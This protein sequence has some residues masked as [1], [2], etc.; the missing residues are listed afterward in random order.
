MRYTRIIVHMDQWSNHVNLKE[1]NEFFC[2]SYKLKM[3]NVVIFF[4]DFFKTH[5][6]VQFTIFPEF[7]LEFGLYDHN[8]SI[9]D[10]LPNRLRNL[11]GYKLRT[12]ADHYEPRA[13]EYYNKNNET[14]LNGYLGR[15]LQTI[16]ETLN[17]T[18][19]FP[20]QIPHD[21]LIDYRDILEYISNYSID[22][23]ASSI[24]MSE[25]DDPH[26]FSYTFEM[27]K[28]CLLLPMEKSLEFKELFLMVLYSQLTFITLI[29]IVLFTIVF[30]LALSRKFYQTCQYR[31]PEFI[32]ND[33]AIRGVLGQAFVMSSYRSVSLKLIYLMLMP[34][35]LAISTL[36]GCYLLTFCT[37][38]P[39]EPEIETYQDLA[40]SPLKVAINRREFE[41]LHNITNGSLAYMYSKFYI[42]SEFSDFSR[43]R[44]SFDRR[45]AY[46]AITSKLFYYNSLQ[47][48][49]S[50]KFF[51]FS[52]KMCPITM[53]LFSFPLGPN[54]YFL[55]RLDE[56]IL[57]TLQS[58]LM[59]YWISYS[60]Q[61][62]VAT[63]RAIHMNISNVTEDNP[64][65]LHDLYWLWVCYLILIT[66][67]ILV[68]MLELLVN[69]IFKN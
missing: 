9:A 6:Y 39:L 40:K 52:T 69:K 44:D 55:P 47:A 27:S 32:I 15:F 53:M 2:Y 35:G 30:Y 48:Y 20:L 57:N 31:W 49:F 64:L 19:Y 50:Q 22:I 46:H 29:F 63:G 12:I 51:R 10:I 45:F 23:P 65:H 42:L 21:K 14:V 16:S 4:K 34:C 62:V 24:A 67:A 66:V 5:Q 56:I 28:W 18:L 8:T 11:K 26:D 60:Y 43:L 68:F 61:D 36:F 7:K 38:P 25:S 58:G 3:L 41:N 54:S 37:Q 1:L 17:S 13:M 33:M 59:N